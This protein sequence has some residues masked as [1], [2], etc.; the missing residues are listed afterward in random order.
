MNPRR[1]FRLP[2]ASQPSGSL[3]P[4]TSRARLPLAATLTASA[5]LLL[6][7]PGLLSAATG[8]PLPSFQHPDFAGSANCAACHTGLADAARQDVSIDTH[9]R[10][11]MMA[12]SGRDPLWQAK[13]AS[14][15][16]RNPALKSV[17]EN[18]CATCHLPMARTQAATLGSP[19]AIHGDGFLNPAN[20]YHTAA[21]DGV[22]CSLCHQIRA[23]GLG[24]AAS[25]S[26]QYRID[27][28]TEPPL[29]VIYGQYPNP[30]PNQMQNNL[31]FTPVQGAH[32]SSSALCGTC[33]N[34]RTPYVDAAGQI[35]GEF[36]EQMIYSEWEHSAFNSTGPA[37]RSCQ[38]CHMPSAT[39]GVVLSNR[40]GPGI[41][42][43][44]RAPFSQH[45][46]VGG[47]LF[48]L[49]LLAANID[50][51]KLTA[52]S[53]NFAAT[54]ERTR[55]QLEESTATLRRTA[56][57]VTDDELAVGLRVENLAGHKLP[58]GIPTRR[59]WIHLTV[60]DATGAVLFSS[61]EPLPDGRIAGNDADTSLSACE[62]HY[63]VLTRPDQVQIY[64]GVMEDTD[65]A[66]TYTLLRG[67]RF[68]KDNRLLPA[69]FNK[70]TASP[71]IAP[72][73]AAATD[74]T[75][76]GGADEVTYRIA[77]AGRPGPFTVSARL[78]YQTV[79]HAFAA[80]LLT[81]AAAEPAIAAF[82]ALYERAT[83]IPATLARL[84]F[85]VDPANPD[86]TASPPPRLV[87]LSSRARVG[88]D[89]SAVI[90]GFVVAGT[91]SKPLLIRA[92]GPTLGA[93]P[94]NLAGTLPDPRLEVY[95]GSTL[96]AT[97]R[98]LASSQDRAAIIAAAQ[99]AGAF[100][101]GD[102]GDDAAVL[103]T[104]PPGAYT[105]VVT[106]AGAR[107]GLI[108]VEAY[109]LAATRPAVRLTNLSTRAAAGA[110][111]DALVGGIVLAGDAPK[112][113]LFRAVGPGLAGFGVAGALTRPVL[114]LYSAGR[115]VATNA[116]W[117][118]SPDVSAI[119]AAAASVSAFS[120]ANGDAA[121]LVTLPPGGYT[122]EVTGAGGATGIALIEAYE[123][124]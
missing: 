81:D 72:A 73:G 103:A 92:V 4:P 90:A 115:V 87:N 30:F 17:I 47:N 9:W 22:S 15:T 95:R 65:G 56:F 102:A 45:H 57:T 60:R 8:L 116:N 109:D 39:G 97:N 12:N 20:G 88:A 18:K 112:R 82:A 7:A 6:L 3:L 91:E 68:R 2:P 96:L 42:L 58:S 64:E 13:V 86:A 114:T 25:F 120:L 119:A 38:Q 5:A 35:R 34:L 62:P 46:F 118:T 33:H 101:L 123:L 53:E 52:S 28:T 11:T 77:R 84:E 93:A 69:G 59:A 80:D 74:T 51:L 107:S 85:A 21:V 122:A 41:G 110:G 78:L 99:Q 94:F 76:I 23:D 48:M 106:S 83:K 16:R 89:D 70:S 100:P 37:A 36:P 49:D 105:A 29:R 24:L 113:L 71:D 19:V 108:L 10:S 61:G 50:P 44:A 104:L 117:S 111:A 79:S 55:A 98:G 26:G 14:E 27:T 43:T 54:R 124:P 1:L 67:A 66:V 32:V 121:L 40:G 63:D 75:F 31:G